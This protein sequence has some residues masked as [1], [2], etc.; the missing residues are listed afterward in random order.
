M[1]FGLTNA[2]AVCQ[3]LFNDVLRD[4]LNTCVFVYLDDILIFSQSQ[5]EHVQHV[6][7]V[8]RRLLENHL[9]V[10]AGKCEFHVSEV[11]F[12]G[13]I[14]REGSIQMD[15]AKFKAVLD[16]ASPFPP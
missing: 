14:L 13:F 4:L 9:F 15:P 2:P 1:L 12:L 6:R 16:W 3:A 8:L 5:E 10:K 11:S 7:Y